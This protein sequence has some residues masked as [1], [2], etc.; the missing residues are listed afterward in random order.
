MEVMCCLG[1]ESG[2]TFRFENGTKLQTAFEMFCARKSRTARKT[3]PARAFAENGVNQ[4][5]D[6]IR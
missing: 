1:G 3:W 6:K 5:H 2:F 4:Y